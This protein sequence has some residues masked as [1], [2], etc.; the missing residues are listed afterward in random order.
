MCNSLDASTIVASC[1][2]YYNGT[3]AD[4]GG[5]Y[6]R[7]STATIINS[8]FTANFAY[9]YGGAIHSEGSYP[10]VTNC[11]LWG[12]MAMQA[13]DEIGNTYSAVPV[14]S[15][16]DIQGSGGSGAGWR[17]FL[18]TDAGGNIDAH[19]IFVDEVVVDHRLGASSPC[20][21]TGDDAALPADAADLDGDGDTAEPL[22]LDLDG[23]PRVSGS[24]V[25]MGAYE[26]QQ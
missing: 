6:N 15:H 18:G 22:P 5:I 3:V 21:D 1:F 24:Y 13:G 20:I 25:D 14:F 16:C 9:W 8:T 11:I 2:F 7:D 23:N 10:L 19:P 12:D 4:G 17:T 26:V